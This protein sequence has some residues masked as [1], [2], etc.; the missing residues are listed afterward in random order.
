MRI[1]EEYN[2]ERIDNE[3]DGLANE[4]SFTQDDDLTSYSDN[5]TNIND[6]VNDNPVSNEV[7]KKDDEDNNRRK[8]NK[9][10]N[11]SQDNSSSNSSSGSS[12]GSAS[13]TGG[14]SAAASVGASVVTVAVVATL[15]G[16]SVFYGGKC[17]V[18]DVITTTNTLEYDLDLE[19]PE[20]GNCLLTLKDT[21][22]RYEETYELSI[23]NNTGTFEGLTPGTNYV[24]TVYD[25]NYDNY[26]LFQRTY[27]TIATK[28]WTIKFLDYSGR[29]YETQTV[30]DG[31]YA[32][33]IEAPSVEGKGFLGWSQ[34]S[35]ADSEDEMFDFE[36]PIH[37][38]YTLFSIYGDK[39]ITSFKWSI[40]LQ[41]VMLNYTMTYIDPDNELSDL[42]ITFSVYDPSVDQT[43]E[44]TYQLTFAESGSVSLIKEGSNIRFRDNWYYSYEIR[45]YNSAIAD[46]VI[47][48]SNGTT[49]HDQDERVCEVSQVEV[50]FDSYNEFITLHFYYNDTL[51][52]F[53]G[54]DPI[55]STVQV[56]FESTSGLYNSFNFTVDPSNGGS[57]ELYGTSYSETEQY[58]FTLT[59][60]DTRYNETITLAQGTYTMESDELNILSLYKA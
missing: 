33:Q 23:G 39:G 44:E 12:S 3:T 57:N 11:D 48:Q 32:Y 41:A 16:I 17:L 5:E 14:A 27:K 58:L 47:Y 49:L 34:Y 1:D 6:D 51:G 21:I 43:Y 2:Y 52:L 15:V 59:A 28:T 22:G 38:D 13:A 20:D 30:E 37:Q 35:Y 9:D 7:K 24:F 29:L 50:A 55:F 36:M 18:N 8:E 40:D 60:I 10:N 42:E 54:N 46:T 45:Y 4:F 25:V 53:S 19:T 56:N 26:V 31:E